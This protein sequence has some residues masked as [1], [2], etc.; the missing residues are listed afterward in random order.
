[1]K[2][3]PVTFSL[4]EVK[5]EKFLSSLKQKHIL[6]DT[7]FLI[8]ANHNQQSFSEIIQPLKESECT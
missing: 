5:I 4:V 1:M 7:N 2:T 6:I 8:D 3:T